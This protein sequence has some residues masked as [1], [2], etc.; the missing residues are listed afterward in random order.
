MGVAINF[1]IFP[2]S[3]LG[4]VGIRSYRF[5]AAAGP[6]TRGS[7]LFVAQY[8]PD[9]KMLTCRSCTRVE[10]RVPNE[11]TEAEIMSNVLYLKIGFAQDSGISSAFATGIQ[12]SVGP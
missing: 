5:H 6:G 10:S 12:I 7:F 1:V 11:R 2:L 9:H 3:S 8:S 4:E